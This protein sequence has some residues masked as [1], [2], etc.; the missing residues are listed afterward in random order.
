MEDIL[1]VLLGGVLALLGSL[2]AHWLQ[3]SREK[4]KRR[5]DVNFELIKDA[6]LALE[7]YISAL[8]NMLSACDGVVRRNQT[9]DMPEV[10]KFLKEA[11]EQVQSHRSDFRK[12]QSI[13]RLVFNDRLDTVYKELVEV[14]NTIRVNVIFEKQLPDSDTIKS[15]VGRLYQAYYKIFDEFQNQL[16]DKKR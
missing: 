13:T 8:S 11:D 1:K 14:E 9:L 3:K 4:T 16:W 12:S 5:F 6:T 10:Q 7:N 2:L 15:L